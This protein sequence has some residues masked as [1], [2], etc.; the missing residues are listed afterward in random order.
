VGVVIV[1]A[2]QGKRVGGAVP[3]QYRDLAGVPMLLR[4]IR[5]FAAHPEVGHTVVVLPAADIASPPPWLTELLGGALSIVAGGAERTDSV[6]LGVAALPEGCD[7]VLVHDAAR[8]LV[9]RALIDAVV[10][11]ARG[12]E[13]AIPALPVGDTLKEAVA[14]ERLA[15]VGAG[16]VTPGPVV[17]RTIPRDRLW[18][19]QTPQGFPRAVLERAHANARGAGIQGTD[20]AMLVERLGVPVRLVPG[21][22]WNLKVTTEDD[23]RLA[24]RLL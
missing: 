12:G 8:P 5:P 13:G 1:A 20:D 9:E 16:A 2:G 11:V 22:A 4:A 21:S 19:A 24:E 6:R 15:E 3:K 17:A 10:A 18:Q 23:L 14:P 7:V